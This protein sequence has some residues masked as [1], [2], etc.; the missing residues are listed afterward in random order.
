[1]SNFKNLGIFYYHYYLDLLLFIQPA[2]CQIV[3][4][5]IKFYDN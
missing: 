3:E 2:V 5:P 1:M 4:V